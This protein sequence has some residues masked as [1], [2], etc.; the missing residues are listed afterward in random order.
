MH[1]CAHAH[2]HTHTNIGKTAG[3]KSHNL[4]TYTHKVIHQTDM[5]L[6]CF[7]INLVFI[8]ILLGHALSQRQV[9]SFGQSGVRWAVGLMRQTVTFVFSS[10][11]YS[12]YVYQN[13]L[14][15]ML[16]HSM[17]TTVYH[18]SQREYK[19]TRNVRFDCWKQFAQQKSQREYKL[20]RNTYFEFFP[21]VSIIRLHK[22]SK[23]QWDTTDIFTSLLGADRW[24]V[25][26]F[27][28]HATHQGPQS[29]PLAVPL[30]TDLW[31]K[32]ME[33]IHASWCP[34][35]KHPDITVLVGWA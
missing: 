26:A 8:H 33:L 15:L 3:A 4:H 32:R 31:P 18:K 29:S 2:T 30:W 5:P 27:C 9:H 6:T 11:D 19:L 16:T 14:L 24:E 17:S 13:Y 34:L 1:A 22:Q 25:V 10:E 21:H 12:A 23:F 35:K 28:S 7:S 20:A